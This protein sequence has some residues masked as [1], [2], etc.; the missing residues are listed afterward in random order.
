MQKSDGLYTRDMQKSILNPDTNNTDASPPFTSTPELSTLG[1]MNDLNRTFSLD[2]PPSVS[3]ECFTCQEDSPSTVGVDAAMNVSVGVK[4]EKTST[5]TESQDR[6]KASSSTQDQTATQSY[7]EAI[8]RQTESML[9]PE[10]ITTQHPDTQDQ[11]TITFSPAQDQRTESKEAINLRHDVLPSENATTEHIYSVAQDQTVTFKTTAT[12]RT[13]EPD[14]GSN[15]TL[16]RTL[17]P[18]TRS[19]ASTIAKVNEPADVLCPEN[20]TTMEMDSTASTSPSQAPFP[21]TTPR[22]D[23]TTATVRRRPSTTT[24]T[25][26]SPSLWEWLFG[27]V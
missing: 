4:E 18:D 1:G 20:G 13:L 2:E 24:T 10:N 16:P 19:N 3:T 22:P 26:A 14:M 8:L 11:N 5:Q 27:W 25:T 23:S 12:P 7:K 6:T 21:V 9:S 15:T 17:E